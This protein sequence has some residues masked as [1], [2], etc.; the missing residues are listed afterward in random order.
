MMKGRK[1]VQISGG[2]W[3]GFLRSQVSLIRSCS[4]PPRGGEEERDLATNS[5]SLG[6]FHGLACPV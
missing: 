1:V 6:S 4:F 5:R 2:T 3:K